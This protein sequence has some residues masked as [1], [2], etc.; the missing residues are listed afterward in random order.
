METDRFR[1]IRA[2]P[3]R[4]SVLS[5]LRAKCH[6]SV[7]KHRREILEQYRE[8]YERRDAELE[9]KDASTLAV[10]EMS[11][12]SSS[13]VISSTSSG[14]S[15]H[16][17]R[18]RHVPS[19]YTPE[20]RALLLSRLHAILQQ[21]QQRFH[22]TEAPLDDLSQSHYD[23]DDRIPSAS[24]RGTTTTLSN[25]PLR[26]VDAC[27]LSA[28][29]YA[30]LMHSM[31]NELMNSPR[32]SRGPSHGLAGSTLISEHKQE[33]LDDLSQTAEDDGYEMTDEE[34]A[35]LLA[36]EEQYEDI[37]REVRDM[38]IA[39]QHIRDAEL[40]LRQQIDD[41]EQYDAEEDLARELNLDDQATLDELNTL[42]TDFL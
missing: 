19:L 21:E 38:Y 18:R 27:E 9:A 13:K 17:V 34:I 2:L 32:R 25:S 30:S 26:R 36:L 6:A 42:L 40:A 12:S 3:S 24:A 10:P 29:E 7:R 23:M 37:D 35:A 41:A 28:D 11:N 16:A 31:R 39:E 15:F 33:T 4:E 5:E 8:S 20:G 22:N 1:S 14:L